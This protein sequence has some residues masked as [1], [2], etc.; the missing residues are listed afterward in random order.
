M[1][2]VEQAIKKMRD[3][4][5]NNPAPIASLS[6]A[7]PVVDDGASAPRP[8]RILAVDRAAL[9]TAGF[10][11]PEGESHEI[12]DQYRQIKRPLIAGAIGRGGAALP[13]GHAIMISS[14][15]PGEGKTFTSINLALSIA[16]EKDVSALLIDS[17]VARPQLSRLF[18]A[19]NE[20]GLLD[21]LR[22]KT[23]DVASA[24]LDTDVPGLSVLPAGSNVDAAPELL[25]SARMRALIARL[26]SR[27]P[28]RILIFD[29]APLLLTSEPKALAEVVG[30]IVVV[31]R[32]SITPQSAVLDAIGQLGTGKSVGLVLNQC[33]DSSL[34]SY[35]EKYPG[36]GDARPKA[37]EP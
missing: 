4:R 31:V 3:A 36:Y 7:P 34:R 19:E 5:G 18:G 14:S 9:R 37:S 2:L 32:A 8:S 27:N 23:L 10:M 15:F 35:Y 11:A 22:D 6:T 12:A 29:S 16:T 13:N 24:T 28:N 20:L 25:S 1:S 21:V 33:E 26:I 30:Q 17:D